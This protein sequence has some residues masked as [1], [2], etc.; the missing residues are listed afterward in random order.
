[1]PSLDATTA[2]GDMEIVPV[3]AT[4]GRALSIRVKSAPENTRKRNASSARALF[5]FV[6]SDIVTRSEWPHFTVHIIRHGGGHDALI[7][8]G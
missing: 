6:C 5:H 8:E 1:M 2:E 3:G 7:D 4:A